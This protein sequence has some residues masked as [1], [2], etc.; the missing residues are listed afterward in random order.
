[1]SLKALS[2]LAGSL[3]FAL[4]L[5]SSCGSDFDHSIK[6]T[7]N[8][9]GISPLTAM[10]NIKAEKP[11]KASI[12][13]L[14]EIPVEQIF[15]MNSASLE[16]PVVGLYPNTLN[17]V[18]LTLDYEG[19]K[20]TDTISIK[21]GDIPS[22]F[23]KIVINKLN[24]NEMEQ[25]MHACDIHF[26]NNGTFNS[27]PMIFDDQGQVRWYLDLS[28]ANEM[29]SPFQRLKDGTLLMV[30]RHV[31]YEFDML[32]K[33]LKKSNINTNYGMHHDVVELPDGNLLICIGKKGTFINLDGN[34]VISDSDFIMLYDRKKSKIVKEW[35]LAKHLDV[36]KNE[37][38]FF[39]PGDWLHMNGLAFDPG[40]NSII[41]SGK[42][43][44]LI[45][46]SWNDT[47]QWI[48]APKRNWGKSG[49]DGKGFETNPYLLTAVDS[50]GKSYSNTV[51]D[52]SESIDQFDFPWGM[53]SP[54]QMPNG[55]LLVFDNG[56]FR[57][58]ENNTHYSRAAEYKINEKDKT[59]EQVWQYGKERGVEFFSSIIGDVDYL[60]RSNNVLITSG[61]I[62]K[63]ASLTAKIVEVDYDTG[64]E[65][66]EATLF[67]KSQN[68][69][70]TSG[71]GQSDILYR[72]ER[73]ELKY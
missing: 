58:F 54:E 71:W 15:D 2:R 69:N 29:V 7:L 17:Y 35:D 14:G 26:A 53:H 49:R 72:S 39:R 28:F 18:V 33:P 4:L 43:Q 32:G 50:E 9:Y 56:V 25:G 47:L 38:N 16:I 36:S 59:V 21:T 63:G 5:F 27:G 3:V 61:F 52:G 73:L 64:Q 10:L 24:R 19:G 31:I 65:V 12:K 30:S 67:L 1:M 22:H 37:L 23:P 40:D 41:V 45:N 8:P 20:S 70:K 34:N 62:K 51:Q 44:G 6:T 66:F 11:C 46:I 57:N 42:N 13:V 55:N 68:G 60:A 48:M